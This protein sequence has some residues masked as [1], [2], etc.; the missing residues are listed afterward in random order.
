MRDISSERLL[1]RAVVLNRAGIGLTTLYSMMQ[2]GEFPRAVPITRDKNGRPSRV[3]WPE[4]R[5]DAW[6]AQR[7][8]QVA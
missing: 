5:V 6:L 1:P 4:S 3:G 7:M 2:S 8:A